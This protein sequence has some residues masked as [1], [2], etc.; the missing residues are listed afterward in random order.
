M[1]LC[2]FGFPLGTRTQTDDDEEEDGATALNSQD[3]FTVPRL[4]DAMLLQ[5]V[6]RQ[7]PR[8]RVSDPV[9]GGGGGGGD[10]ALGPVPPAGRLK[11][12]DFPLS[13]RRRRSGSAPERRVNCVLVG[14]GA[15]GKTS[16]VVSYT[17]NGYPTEYVPTA[18]DNFTGNNLL[19]YYLC[20]AEF[21]L[22][23]QVLRT[24][25]THNN[26]NNFSAVCLLSVSLDSHSDGGGG[27][28]AGEAAALRHGRTGELIA[29]HQ[30]GARVSELEIY[31]TK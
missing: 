4:T 6:G 14:D 2:H 7:K 25:F 28:E 9:C 29:T 18:F 11:N 3:N 19:Y 17:T 12:R 22:Y 26:N 23:A 15:V 21:D 24:D 31:K 20:I 8:R 5:D 10:G 1:V 16:L 27:R 30:T 13:A